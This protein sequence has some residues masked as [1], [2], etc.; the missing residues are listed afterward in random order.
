L[1]STDLK[2]TKEIRF[3]G[4]AEVVA[5]MLSDKAFRERVAQE[6]GA[7]SYSV[8]VEET[9]DGVRSVIKVGIPLVGGKVETI[10]GSALGRVLKVQQRV[11]AEWLAEG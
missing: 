8:L 6:A 5:A 9:A 3:P 1:R 7:A 11:G 10:I 2:F 4:S